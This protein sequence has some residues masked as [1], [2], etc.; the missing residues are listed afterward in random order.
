V[1]RKSKA[2]AWRAL[3]LLL[4]YAAIAIHVVHWKATGRTLSPLEPSESMQFSKSSLVNAGL[5]F[6]ALAIGS[7][8]L[9]GRWFCGWGCHVVALQDGSRWL[10]RRS[11]SVRAP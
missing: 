2:G 11:G 7:T 6:F 1:I 8:L 10:S 4:V 5:V 9:L 3:V